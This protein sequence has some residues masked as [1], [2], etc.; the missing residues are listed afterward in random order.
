VWLCEHCNEG[1]GNLTVR[2]TLTTADV[3][4]ICERTYCLIHVFIWFCFIMIRENFPLY[5][6][7]SSVRRFYTLRKAVRVKMCR[8]HTVNSTV[9]MGYGFGNELNGSEFNFRYIK[10]ASS[11]WVK[12]PRDEADHSTP[13]RAEDKNMWN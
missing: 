6:N 13:S 7:S 9:G 2:D 12:H 11:S 3:K 5:M 1:M 10:F 4:S 8:A